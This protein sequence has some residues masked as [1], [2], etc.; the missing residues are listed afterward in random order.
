MRSAAASA[1]FGVR[2]IAAL[3]AVLPLSVTMA[4]PAWMVALQPSLDGFLIFRLAPALSLRFLYR[5]PY[6]VRRQIL[7]VESVGI[8]R[9][10]RLDS[11]G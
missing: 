10:S 6:K 5:F 11:A 8:C 1:L 3:S 4:W 9:L 2:A 7:P